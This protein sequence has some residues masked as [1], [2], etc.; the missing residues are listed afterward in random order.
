MIGLVGSSADGGRT[1]SGKISGPGCTTFSVQRVAGSRVG[2]SPPQSNSNESPG[3]PNG[4]Q[5]PEVAAAAPPAPQPQ[6]AAVQLPIQAATV[7]PAA[8]PLGQLAP[9]PGSLRPQAGAQTGLAA[10]T[11]AQA[12]SVP[13]GFDILGMKLGMSIEEIQA[14]IKAHDPTLEIIIT[15]GTMGLLNSGNDT[16]LVGDKFVHFLQANRNRATD[17]ILEF[18]SVAFTVTE[19]RRAFY[20]GRSTKFPP[21]QQPLTD[22]TV[23]QLRE[24][25]GTESSLLGSGAN[26]YVRILDWVFD[27]A[28]KQ[29]VPKN[30]KQLFLTPDHACAQSISYGRSFLIGG[31]VAPGSYSPECGADLRVKL[32]LSTNPNLLSALFEQLTGDSIAVDD[33]QKLMAEAKAA[34]EQQRQQQEQKASGVKAPL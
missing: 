4:P 13:A 6:S 19:P 32:E 1:Y 21:E 12:A 25:Y 14:A 33:I 18:I 9:T 30:G 11:A 17:P 16:M 5:Q 24:K 27:K 8:P 15:E 20:I 29:L 26:S 34:K 22:K 23:Q 31:L 7:A 28:G 10:A 3:T 2:N